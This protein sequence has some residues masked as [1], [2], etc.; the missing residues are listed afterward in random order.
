MLKRTAN[1]QKGMRFISLSICVLTVCLCVAPRVCAEQPSRTLPVQ[2]Q[3]AWQP[4][5]QPAQTG[6]PIAPL[7]GVAGATRKNTGKATLPAHQPASAKSASGKRTGGQGNG[8]SANPLDIGKNRNTGDQVRASIVYGPE[9]PKRRA[10]APTEDNGRVV[11]SSGDRKLP[12][13]RLT[14]ARTAFSGSEHTL[15][16]MDTA[17]APEISMKYKLDER[18]AT[19]FTVNPQDPS[20][21]LY[22]PAEIEGKVN[23]A[24]LYMDMDVRPDVQVRVGGE[25]S[26]FKS[27]DSPDDSAR[28]A[29]VGVKWNF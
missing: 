3:P 28:G 24:G 9:G 5:R 17:P 14:P 12:E 22:R 16:Y 4:A 21:P 8:F 29:S 2:G 20:S 7:P 19:R 10:P 27:P 26:E 15:P 18:T 1:P 11:M 23:S 6:R 25:Y 13:S